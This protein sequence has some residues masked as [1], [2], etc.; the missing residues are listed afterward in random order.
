VTAIAVT[1]AVVVPGLRTARRAQHWMGQKPSGRSLLRLRHG[2]A[3]P[4][5]PDGYR[6]EDLRSAT[7]APVPGAELTVRRAADPVGEQLGND[8]TF[9]AAAFDK[10]AASR[11]S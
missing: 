4:H 10:K 7:G 3:D 2:E 8:H 11:T 6:G 5:G 9:V 1:A